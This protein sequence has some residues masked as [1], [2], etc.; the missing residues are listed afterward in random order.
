MGTPGDDVVCFVK[1][2]SR[3]VMKWYRR[4]V[5]ACAILLRRG[6]S[7]SVVFD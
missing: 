7:N 5:A 6:C 4:L 2:L 3:E 1:V